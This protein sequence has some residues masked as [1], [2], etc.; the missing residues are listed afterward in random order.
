MS[1][2]A[3]QIGHDKRV[4]YRNFPDQCK[5]ISARYREF[6]VNKSNQRIETIKEEINNAF[7]F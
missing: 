4:L 5:Q 3:N 6:V 7:L 2:A 1:S